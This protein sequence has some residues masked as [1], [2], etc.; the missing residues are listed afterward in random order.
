[1]RKL[2][3]K[4]IIAM[5]LI[6]TSIL[7][8]S[9]TGASASWKKDGTG[10]WYQNDNGTWYYF[11][12]DGSMVTGNV[13]IGTT[14]NSFSS[15]G[16]WLGTTTNSNTSS[17]ASALSAMDKVNYNRSNNYEFTD[18]EYLLSDSE[19]TKDFAIQM[20]NKYAN[21]VSLDGSLHGT[22]TFGGYNGYPAVDSA[23][24]VTFETNEGVKH[25]K[26]WLVGVVNT[27]SGRYSGFFE[28]L[29]NGY[30]QYDE[31][32]ITPHFVKDSSF[33]A[34]TFD[35]NNNTFDLPQFQSYM[36]NTLSI[37]EQQ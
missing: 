1:M 6:T 20:A 3:L 35:K 22:L 26:A 25:Y 5:G 9:S 36:S 31:N 27:P 15:T 21:L 29:N 13:I 19:F 18:K 11:K 23:K 37:E 12:G 24:D 7:A 17:T 10:W 16:A 8:V 30:L 2:N 33:N 34:R 14:M 28:I 4:K 32:G